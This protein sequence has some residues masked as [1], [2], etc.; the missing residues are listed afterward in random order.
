MADVAPVIAAIAADESAQLIT[1]STLTTTNRNGTP[2]GKAGSALGLVKLADKTIQVIGTFG[3][4]A[5]ITV[6]GSNDGTNW[7]TLT[8]P[9]G[10]ALT[11]TAASLE[12]ITENPRFIRPALTNGDGSTDIDVLLVAVVGNNLR[13]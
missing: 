6:Q 10:N 9:L 5:T 8:D 12:T 2:A 1:W 4:S 7:A 13:T 3:A 11:S